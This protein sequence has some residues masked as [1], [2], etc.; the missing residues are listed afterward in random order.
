M[1]EQTYVKLSL[2]DSVALLVIERPPV[3]ALN[4][5]ALDELASVCDQLFADAQVRAVVITGAGESAFV[6]GADIREIAAIKDQPDAVRAFV[7]RGQGLFNKIEAAP[8]PVIAAVNGVALGGGLELAMAC[9]IRLFSDRARVGQTETNLGILPGWGGTQR[10]ARLIG[11][12]RALE[13]IL[14]GEIIDAQ[15]AYRLGLANRVVPAGQLL[16]EALALAGKIA[17]KSSRVNRSVLR[18]VLD[19]LN[20]PLAE[21]LRY[22]AELFTALAGSHDMDE[23]LRAFLEKRKPHFTD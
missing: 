16:E 20:M 3:N 7:A 9:H 4:A 6:A 18:A 2:R 11:P 21:G 19:G 12:G 10:L 13:L 17:G 5:A 14:T 23:G 15:E 1:D 8:K 22:E